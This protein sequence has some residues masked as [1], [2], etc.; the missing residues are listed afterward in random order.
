MGSHLLSRIFS[1]RVAIRVAFAFLGMA[2]IPPVA[3]AAALSKPQG[4]YHITPYDGVGH[5]PQQT[6][7]DGGGG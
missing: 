5:G 3:D 7:M 6:G 4:P 2:T 1:V